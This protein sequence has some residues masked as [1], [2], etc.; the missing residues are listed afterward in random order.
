[1]HAT[2]TLDYVVILS[3]EI[4]LTTGGQTFLLGPGDLV[5]QRGARPRLDNHGSESCFAA[6]D[7]DQRRAAPES[8]GS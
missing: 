4:T 8:A 3:G 7:P 6:V 1:M 2:A 5:V